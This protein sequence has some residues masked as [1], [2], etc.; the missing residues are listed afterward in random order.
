M[1]AVDPFI[2]VYFGVVI[3]L[4]GFIVVEVRRLRKT[5]DRK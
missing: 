2:H 5:A 1:G 3:V 4:L